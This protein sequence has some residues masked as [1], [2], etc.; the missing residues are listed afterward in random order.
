MGYDYITV[1]GNVASNRSTNTLASSGETET[2]TYRV[3]WSAEAGFT[4]QGWMFGEPG[5]GIEKWWEENYASLGYANDSE[6]EF[7][8]Y[9]NSVANLNDAFQSWGEI[10]KLLWFISHQEEFGY[11]AEHETFARCVNKLT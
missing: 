3:E 5:N 7:K 10:N 9:A 1:G 2:I 11:D 8:K 4:D 6:D